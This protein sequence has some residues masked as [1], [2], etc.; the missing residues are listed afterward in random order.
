MARTADQIIDDAKALPA[1]YRARVAEEVLRSIDP[2]GQAQVDAAWAAV[3]E[4]RLRRHAAGGAP[5]I[6]VDEAIDEVRQ[7]LRGRRP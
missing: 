2:P 3:A 7:L 1:E 6:P 5:A 4:D